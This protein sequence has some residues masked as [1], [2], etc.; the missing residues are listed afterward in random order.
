MRLFGRSRQGGSGSVEDGP[1][2]PLV[3]ALLQ[4]WGAGAA[5]ARL[6][7]FSA[8]TP[9]FNR[10]ARRAAA[11]TLTPA[12][13]PA[14]LATGLTAIAEGGEPQDPRAR[15]DALMR[16]DGGLMA[17]RG[18]SAFAHDLSRIGG[19]CHLLCSLTPSGIEGFTAHAARIAATLAYEGIR[20]W[21][22]AVLD[23]RDSAPDAALKAM[24]EF[25]E[26]VAGVEGVQFATISGRAF[27][28]DSSADKKALS[29]V[30]NAV[31]DADPQTRDGLGQFIDAQNRGGIIDGDITPMADIAYPGM[32]G[33]DALLVLH[34]QA[35]GLTPLLRTLLP[36]GGL[37]IPASRPVTLSACRRVIGWTQPAPPSLPASR[38]AALQPLLTLEPLQPRLPSVLRDAGLTVAMAVPQ[39]QHGLWAESME[40][41]PLAA[42]RAV[43]A[44]TALD[45]A[46]AA[47][48]WIK[49]GETDVIFALLGGVP[50]SA[51]SLGTMASGS[52]ARRIVEQQDKA[53][54][55]LAA[56]LERRGG[57]LVAMGTDTSL[58]AASA[59]PLLIHGGA[60]T[61]E[62]PLATGTLANVA[63]TLLAL[64]GLPLEA[65]PHRDTGAISTP[66][67][68]LPEGLDAAS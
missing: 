55:R 45:V 13:V 26:D 49:Q 19:D 1:A 62:T 48:Q 37:T 52:A 16:A 25:R 8:R 54:G 15:L 30:R 60:V 14:S 53:L 10:L 36:E 44:P 12:P 18:F 63:P 59:L 67:L 51:R 9:A 17:D 42:S 20:V 33:D 68:T 38:A 35:E 34:P 41:C 11:T 43:P 28:L 64:A 32:R 7:A 56:I 3:I 27:A 2:R 50:A 66:L 57:T 29:L 22:H 6:P 58:A 31:V 39:A 21:V 47:V 5:D 24:H 40:G 65:M 61:Q 46:D 4:G 23:G